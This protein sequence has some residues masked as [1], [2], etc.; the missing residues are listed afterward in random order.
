MKQRRILE[1]ILAGT[2]AAAALFSSL[3]HSEAAESK[4]AKTSQSKASP[5]KQPKKQEKEFDFLKKHDSTIEYYVNYFNSKHNQSLDSNLVRAM[6]V[7]EAG[8]P[9]FRDN[10][11]LYDP[12]QIASD[13]NALEILKRKGENVWLIGLT[14]FLQD[15]KYSE[16]RNSKFD[17]TNSNMTA[18]DSIHGGVL[19]LF[20]KA[21][22]Y[23]TRTIREEEGELKEHTVKERDTYSSIAKRNHTSPQNLE[24]HNPQANPNRLKI[25]SKL[26]FKRETTRTETYIAGWKPWK[27][28]IANYNGSSSYAT[29]VY[30]IRDRIK[31][32]RSKK[33]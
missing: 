1:T 6:I 18:Q 3:N 23:E 14:D 25:G 32:E 17:Y 7:K 24:K 16:R 20:H 8:S 2:L 10:V 31:A 13:G 22:N 21:A 15:A 5:K 30:K 26:K 12:M 11:F 29:E 33:K 19:W 9:E 27:E 28:A 4:R